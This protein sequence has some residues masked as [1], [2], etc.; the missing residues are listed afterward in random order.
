MPTPAENRWTHGDSSE[1]PRSVA[2]S[3]EQA[4]DGDTGPDEDAC[5]EQVGFVLKA[6]PQLPPVP[7]CFAAIRIRWR[8]SAKAA[9]A[10]VSPSDL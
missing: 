3:A 7:R 4:Q 6:R 5:L 10:G 2:E 1:N 9:S 8:P